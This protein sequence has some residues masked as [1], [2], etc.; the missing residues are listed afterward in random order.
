MNTMDAATAIRGLTPPIGS[1]G[2][3]ITP[4][5]TGLSVDTEISPPGMASALFWMLP[6]PS[7]FLDRVASLLN[8]HRAVAV[9]LSERTVL[10]HHGLIDQALARCHFEGP[11]PVMLRVHDEPGVLATIAGLLSEHGVSAA[12]VEQSIPQGPRSSPPCPPWP[13]SPPWP[14]VHGAASSAR[15]AACRSCKADRATS[16]APGRSW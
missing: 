5:L 2:P 11:A 1:Q 3:A 10:G 13:P 9:H 7:A 6:G 12:S 15:Q 4:G 8:N 14:R 16:S